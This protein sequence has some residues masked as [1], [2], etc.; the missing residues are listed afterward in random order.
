MSEAFNRLV[1]VGRTFRGAELLRL[2][3]GEPS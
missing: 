3:I 2:E 1:G